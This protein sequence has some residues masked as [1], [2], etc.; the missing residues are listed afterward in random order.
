MLFFILANIKLTKA[1]NKKNMQL[2]HIIY[3]FESE[4]VL[5]ISKA[6]EEYVRSFQTRDMNVTETSAVNV[7]L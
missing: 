5:S 2:Y 7:G 4:E 3:F 1:N 6:E